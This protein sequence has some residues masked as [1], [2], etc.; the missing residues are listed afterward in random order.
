MFW[1]EKTAIKF[2]NQTV[3]LSA[4]S[5]LVRLIIQGQTLF[6]KMSFIT[7]RSR[8]KIRNKTYIDLFVREGAQKSREKR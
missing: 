8:V 2:E 5:C 3:N 6:I 1:A 7:M 4:D